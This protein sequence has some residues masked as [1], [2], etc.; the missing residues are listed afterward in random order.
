MAFR[1]RNGI[2]ACTA[3]LDPGLWRALDSTSLHVLPA[4]TVSLRSPLRR[5]PSM[6]A[7]IVVPGFSGRA[8][9]ELSPI[10]G[11]RSGFGR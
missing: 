4:P 8:D 9:A 2:P 5:S 7:P 10:P 6:S 1:R 11:K 3:G